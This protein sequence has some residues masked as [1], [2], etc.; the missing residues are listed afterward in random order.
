[1]NT[2]PFKTLITAA[3]HAAGQDQ[4]ETAAILELSKSTLQN[5]LSGSATPHILTQEAALRRLERAD[6]ALD[7]QLALNATR[8]AQAALEGAVKS[9]SDLSQKAAA[10][11]AA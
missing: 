3:M 8:A 5:W 1:M 9:L 10:R 11:V 2:T 6:E 4:E 7:A